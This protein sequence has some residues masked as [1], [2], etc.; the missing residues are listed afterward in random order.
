MNEY[1]YQFERIV[2]N[3]IFENYLSGAHAKKGGLG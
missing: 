2:L 1:F 3:Y